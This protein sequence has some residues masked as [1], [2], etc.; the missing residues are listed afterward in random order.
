MQPESLTQSTSIMNSQC[1]AFVAALRLSAQHCFAPKIANFVLCLHSDLPFVL[2]AAAILSGQ[3]VT[4]KKRARSSAQHEGGALQGS[5]HHAPQTPGLPTE[6]ELLPPECTAQLQGQ[7]LQP[8]QI[9]GMTNQPA[10]IPGMI[11]QPPQT[12]TTMPQGHL[13]YAMYQSPTPSR[14]QRSPPQ[15]NPMSFAQPPLSHAGPALSPAEEACLRRLGA[16][17]M[18]HQSTVSSEQVYQLP[19]RLSMQAPE[20]RDPRAVSPA[21]LPI[22]QLSPVSS[23]QPESRDPRSVSPAELSMRQLSP[24]SSRQLPAQL[25]TKLHVPSPA[26]SRDPRKPSYCSGTVAAT[27]PDP[28]QGSGPMEELSYSPHLAQE[29]EPRPPVSPFQSA[30]FA[31]IQM[32]DPDT[33]S[34]D[35][36][37]RDALTQ[38]SS[39]GRRSSPEANLMTHLPSQRQLSDSL[40]LLDALLSDNYGE[41][42]FAL[43]NRDSDLN[44]GQEDS[45]YAMFSEATQMAGQHAQHAQHDTISSPQPVTAACEDM[46]PTRSPTPR[47]PSSSL[48]SQTLSP[49]QAVTVSRLQEQFPASKSSGS[50]PAAKHSESSGKPLRR[51]WPESPPYTVCRWHLHVMQ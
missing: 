29:P 47:A 8:E 1:L 5:L 38:A 19:R 24:V 49:A 18:S 12:P 33:T 26:T 10:Y 39:P 45:D 27:L 7:L 9:L 14:H 34:S 50:F 43:T 21:E 46:L 22:S 28:E 42:D 6:S 17:S 16:Q 25:P 20:S 51:R 23:R 13:P 35:V 3:H 40:P 2:Q 32:L 30:L 37:A 41:A 15:L 44:L 11:H 31:T 36:N 48:S 4:V